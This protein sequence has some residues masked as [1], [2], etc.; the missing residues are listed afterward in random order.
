ML[1]SFTRNYHDNSTEGGFE[2]TFFCD[3]C[4]DGYKSS[5]VTST[6][7][8]KGKLI[9]GLG[10]GASILGSLAG[11]EVTTSGMPRIA[12]ATSFRSVSKTGAPNG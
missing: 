11:D 1:K 10:A 8:G 3:I 12:G 4:N 6:T 5:F 7:Y 9:K 2:F